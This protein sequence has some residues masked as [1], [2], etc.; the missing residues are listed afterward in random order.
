M[1][2]ISYEKFCMLLD[3]FDEFNEVTFLGLQQKFGLDKV[4]SYFERRANSL[5]EENF[6]AFAKKFQYYF[7]NVCKKDYNYSVEDKRIDTVGYIM[8]VNN[9]NSGNAMTPNEEK[10]FGQYLKDSRK[11]KYLII[12]DPTFSIL[13]PRLNIPILIKSMLSVIDYSKAISL[14]KELKSLP[15]MLNDE[16]I[17]KEDGIYIKKYLKYFSDKRPCENELKIVFPELN[18]NNATSLDDN[19]LFSELDLVKKCIVAKYNFF[20]RNLRWAN[21][22]STNHPFAR[23]RLDEI[24]QEASIGL[25]KAVNKFDIDRGCKFLTYA[26]WWINNSINRAVPDIVNEIRKPIDLY[27]TFIKYKKYVNSY[28]QENGYDPS[29]EL[30]AENLSLTIKQIKELIDAFKEPISL[31][32][33]VDVDGKKTTYGYL[34]EDVRYH[35]DETVMDS[36][37]PQ[38]CERAMRETLTSKEIMVLKKR[39]GIDTE[40]GKKIRLETLGEEMGV[41]RERVRQI[42]IRALGKLNKKDIKYSLKDYLG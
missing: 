16:G 42:E 21:I 3:S 9:G 38:L 41:S 13:Y 10:L 29:L 7:D 39:F 12:N 14:L 36:M 20:M 2:K 6:M 8:L 31:D 1:G 11:S 22:I 35:T 28:R 24:L 15:Y 23:T 4:K 33:P 17:L 34:V 18:F 19:T 26:T 30:I 40:T 25:I 27:L 37:L 5:D 32:A